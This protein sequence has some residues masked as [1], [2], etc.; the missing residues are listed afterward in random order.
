LKDKSERLEMLH[1]V[2]W[3]MEV[4]EYGTNAAKGLLCENAKNRVGTI[5]DYV[6]Y[7]PC[8]LLYQRRGRTC[9]STLGLLFGRNSREVRGWIVEFE[10]ATTVAQLVCQLFALFVLALPF[11]V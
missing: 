8:F 3:E 1:T 10:F 5:F 4:E 7:G 9:W 2:I 6:F 11:A